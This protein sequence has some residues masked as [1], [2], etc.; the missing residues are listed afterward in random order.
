MIVQPGISRFS[1]YE[2]RDGGDS[3]DYETELRA[4]MRRIPGG[5]AN[6]ERSAVRGE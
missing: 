3:N 1:I 6:G 5:L 2:I 4:R